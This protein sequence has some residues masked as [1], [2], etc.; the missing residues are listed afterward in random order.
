MTS[1]LTQNF[2]RLIRQFAAFLG[3]GAVATILDYGV[4]FVGF[5]FLS[6]NPVVAALMGYAAG[7][8]LSY[9]LS[10]RHVFES[11][12]SHRAAVM[13]F[14]G[15]MG[16]GFLLTGYA[17]RVFIDGLLLQPILARILTYGVVLVFNFLAHR[18]FTFGRR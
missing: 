3:V 18:F 8:A 5:W 13:R 7:G 15:V 10:R 12:R 9:T 4:F 16:M 17:M 2:T 6:I 1:H 11:T 14:M